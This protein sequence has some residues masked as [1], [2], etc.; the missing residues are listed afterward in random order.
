MSAIYLLVPRQGNGNGPVVHR[1]PVAAVP[2][3]L[4]LVGHAKIGALLGKSEAPLV[5]DRAVR[6]ASRAAVY[7]L[8]LP[9]DFERIGYVVS[10]LAMWH[11]GAAD[12]GAKAL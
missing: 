8:D 3:A 11:D 2:A 12:P 4:S 6:V 10:Q 5:F 7:R 9:R 1:A